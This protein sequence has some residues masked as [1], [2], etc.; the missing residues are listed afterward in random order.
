MHGESQ[1]LEFDYRMRSKAAQSLPKPDKIETE[2][3]SS[4]LPAA[5]WKPTVGPQCGT[6][7]YRET[8]FLRDTKLLNGMGERLTLFYM[9]KSASS[10]LLP[11]GQGIQHGHSP[12]AIKLPATSFSLG[13]QRIRST[14]R[15]IARR[16]DEPQ[17]EGDEDIQTNIPI[18]GA[19]ERIIMDDDDFPEPVGDDSIPTPRPRTLAVRY[20]PTTMRF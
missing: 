6:G 9:I 10:L 18:P 20:Y 19:G 5:G 17:I 4:T 13:S 15:H 16:P 1:E 3:D 7:E 11:E 2:L 12:Q 8:G 14:T